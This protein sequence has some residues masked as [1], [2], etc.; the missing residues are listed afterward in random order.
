MNNNLVTL[1]VESTYIFLLYGSADKAKCLQGVGPFESILGLSRRSMIAIEDLQLDESCKVL[2][3]CD[4][5]KTILSDFVVLYVQIFQLA[6]G[7]NSEA[8]ETFISGSVRLH[9]QMNK[10]DH[11]WT[12]SQLMETWRFN[13]ILLQR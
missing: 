6:D 9:I 13:C 2:A 8:M 10:V 4:D 1:N 3:L 7:A 5:S 12:H 11:V